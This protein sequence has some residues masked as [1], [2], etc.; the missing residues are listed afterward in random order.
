MQSDTPEP[1]TAPSPGYELCYECDGKRICIY[2]R[3]RG[4]LTNGKT[5]TL[6]FSKGTA[7]TTYTTNALTSALDGDAGTNTTGT[8]TYDTKTRIVT[9]QF[10]TT[11]TGVG[12]VVGSFSDIQL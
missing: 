8:T 1:V 2:C 9:G 7:T 4:K 11:F 12:E 5:M 10:R 3:G 6:F